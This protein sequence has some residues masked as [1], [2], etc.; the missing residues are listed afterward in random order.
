MIDIPEVTV[1][2]D[3]ELPSYREV[4]ELDLPSYE[5]LGT[6]RMQI[7]RNVIVVDRD[8]QVSTFKTASNF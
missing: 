6:K 2:G 5:D 3:T 4:E 7:A 1:Y 8:F